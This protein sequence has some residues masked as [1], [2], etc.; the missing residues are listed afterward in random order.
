MVAVFGTIRIGATGVSLQ[1]DLGKQALIESLEKSEA[2]VLIVAE[3]Y[4]WTISLPKCFRSE[5]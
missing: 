5:K 3:S 1:V 4:Q 2:K